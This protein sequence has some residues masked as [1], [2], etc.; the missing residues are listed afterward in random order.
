MAGIL[1]EKC[2]HQTGQEQI[3]EPD[4]VQLGIVRGP[5][6]IPHIVQ[7]SRLRADKEKLHAKVV[8]ML[9][10]KG[11]VEDVVDNVQVARHIDKQEED[12]RFQGQTRAAASGLNFVP[13]E[14]N[15]CDVQEV[16][17][18]TKGIEGAL[19]ECHVSEEGIP[20]WM[21]GYV[22]RTGQGSL[23]LAGASTLRIITDAK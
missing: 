7:D 6:A 20:L 12:L 3:F 1:E 13:Q 4:R 10:V 5:E 15:G 17:N 18:K 23:G 8:E 11:A 9:Q 14:D 16:T 22:I 21:A 19:I 2:Q